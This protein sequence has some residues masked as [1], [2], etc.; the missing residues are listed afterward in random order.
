MCMSFS[1]LSICV[2]YISNVGLNI[3]MSFSVLFICINYICNVGLKF[4]C[5]SVFL[6]ALIT[7]VMLVLSFCVLQ[8]SF[9]LQQFVMLTLKHALRL[10]VCLQNV[11][12]GH[13]AAE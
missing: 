10:R 1:I 4:L 2:N 7:F 13:Y 11:K 12:I 3:F 6:S 8:Y 5:P 9:H